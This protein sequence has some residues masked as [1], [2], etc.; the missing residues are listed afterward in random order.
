LLEGAA[1]ASSGCAATVHGNTLGSPAVITAVMLREADGLHG[2]RGF[3]SRLDALPANSVWRLA[4]AEL[5]FDIDDVED[6][7][8]AIARGLLDEGT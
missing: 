5:Q 3:G 4:A 6:Q 2:D 8:I 1:G 7:R